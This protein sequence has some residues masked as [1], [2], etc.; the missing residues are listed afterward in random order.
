M[1]VRFLRQVN[2]WDLNQSNAKF[3]GLINRISEVK[4]TER[5]ILQL[6]TSISSNK[7]QEKNQ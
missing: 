7:L 5:D 3:Y 2:V 6:S 4:I 1:F